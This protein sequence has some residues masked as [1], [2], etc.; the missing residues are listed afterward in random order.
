[1]SVD[2]LVDST[3]LDADLTSVANAI[4]T[5]GGTSAQL[6][7]PTGFVTAIGSIPTG[8]TPTGTKS[9]SIVTNGTQTEDVTSYASAE[10]TTN[11]PQ[12]K[13]FVIRP[14]AELFKTYTYD[15]MLVADEGITI[16]EFSTTSVTLKATDQLEAVTPDFASYKYYQTVRTLLIPIYNNSTTGRGRFEW[17]ES[18]GFY[19]YLTREPAGYHSLV[20]ENKNPATRSANWIGTGLYRAGYW[21]SATGYTLYATTSYGLWATLVAPGYTGGT[22]NINSPNVVLRGQVNIL[23]QPF[24]EAITDIRAQYVIEL[25]RVPIGSLQYDGW[26]ATQQ[27]ERVLDCLYSPSQ[28]LL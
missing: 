3:Q 25:W 24:Y 11:V 7:F 13:Q 28:K 6:A 23:D 8:T 4:R 20:D 12:L 18:I 16:P 17:S 9:I 15:Q 1:M 26:S 22:L 21:T 2:K 14:D 19:E 5:K 10:I 27:E